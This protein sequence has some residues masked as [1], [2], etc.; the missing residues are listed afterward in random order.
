MKYVKTKPLRWKKLRTY[1]G[2]RK[3]MALDFEK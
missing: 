3:K 2:Y 1:K